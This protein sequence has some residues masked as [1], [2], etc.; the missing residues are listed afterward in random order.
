[1]ISCCRIIFLPLLCTTEKFPAPVGK[2]GFEF[3]IRKPRIRRNRNYP[4]LK[5]R[6]K[7]NNTTETAVE[8]TAAAPKLAKT[9]T[10]TLRAADGSIMQICAERLKDSARSYILMTDAAKKTTR[11]MTEA[12]PTFEAAKSAIEKIAVKAVKAGWIRP[13]ARRGFEPKP[14]A[15]SDIP[16]PPKAAA[17]APTAPKTTKK[18]KK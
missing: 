1:M 13:E 11:G 16:A 6:L 5:R 18:E 9:A 10:I 12:Y 3:V 4:A 8:T 17:P 14:D 7:M 2:R 15:F